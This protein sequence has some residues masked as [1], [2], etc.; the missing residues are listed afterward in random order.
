MTPTEL[1][2]ATLTSIGL[3]VGGWAIRVESELSKQSTRQDGMETLNTER[4][5]HIAETLGRIESGMD[6][7]LT[8]IER[9]LN[10]HLSKE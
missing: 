2:I 7:R 5:T 4:F 10:G 6:S 8:R 3:P 1:F 9:S